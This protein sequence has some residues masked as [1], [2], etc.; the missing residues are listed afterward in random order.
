M[1]CSRAAV[2]LL[3]PL[4]WFVPG[5]QAQTKPPAKRP[6]AAAENPLSSFRHFSAVMNGGMGG[7]VNRK[8]YRSGDL[9]RL[10]FSDFFRIVNLRNA[11][12]WSVH[13]DRC[14]HG[15]LPDIGAY[16]WVAVRNYKVE[17][18]MSGEKETI[19]GH[20]CNIENATFTAP[21][22][23]LVV[24]MKFWEAEDLKN[25][26]VKIDLDNG[27][28]DWKTYT[29]SEVSLNTPDPDMFKHP[30]RCGALPAPG[31]KGVQERP[32]PKMTPQT[33]KNSPKEP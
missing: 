32:F 15:A 5:T 1:I 23:H 31:Q 16:P 11:D 26:P 18:S 8:I 28:G 29:F 25:F 21:D 14:S 22:G 27:S 13:P 7:D 10:E 2:A 4:L 33:P 24:K 19:D 17:R 6:V 30:S 9:L 3:A 20:S 12:T